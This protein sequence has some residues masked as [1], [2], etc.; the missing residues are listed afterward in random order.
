M[1][2]DETSSKTRFYTAIQ[3]A[4]CLLATAMTLASYSPGSGLLALTSRTSAI[5]AQLELTIVD[6]AVDPMAHPVGPLPDGVTIVA[7][8]TKITGEPVRHH[9]ARLVLSE[10]ESFALAQARL[11]PWLD[12]LNLPPGDRLAWQHEKPE[13]YHAGFTAEEG[14]VPALDDFRTYLVEAVPLVSAPDVQS[15]ELTTSVDGYSS[16]TLR[17]APA[18]AQ[19]VSESTSQHIHGRLAILVNGFVISAPVV[20]QGIDNGILQISGGGETPEETHKRAKKLLLVLTTP[21]PR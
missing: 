1:K 12:T 18:A 21:A 4:C 5:Q 13:D 20:Q 8:M 16:T 2:E 14:S 15:V 10:G 9:Y 7:E 6:D 11:Q 17:L 19:R 3:A